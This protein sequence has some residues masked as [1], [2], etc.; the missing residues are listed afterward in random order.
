MISLSIQFL[1]PGFFAGLIFLSIPIL[2]HLFNFRR[3]KKVA[4][5]NVR[6]LRE[7]KE[8]TTKLNKLK[9]LLILICRLLAIAFIV[10]AF[11]KPVLPLE[12]QKKLTNQKNI[13][14]FV[15]NSF[16]M[17]GV[18][19]DG[20]LLEIAKKKAIE[21]ANAYPSS[22][23]FQLLTSDFLA[24][25]Q[26]LLTKEE[27][28]DEV[29]HIQIS[30][31]SK[32][33]SQVV[34][35]Q[36][37]AFNTHATEE[38][39]LFLISDFQKSSADLNQVKT[40]SLSHLNFI[41]LPVQSTANAYIDSC[42]IESPVVQLNK[43]VELV[44]RVANSGEEDMDNVPVVLK[45]NGSQRAVASCAVPAGNSALVKLSFTIAEPGWQK[46]KVSI[47]DQPIVFDDDYYLSF[48][49]KQNLNVI[50]LDGNNPG[51]YL[52]AL[53][54]N[55][56][57]FKF[58]S[59]PV[60]QVDYSVMQNNQVVILNQL[61]EISGGLTAELKKIV[62]KG[63]TV[64]CFPDTSIDINSYSTALNNLVGEGFSDLI[65]TNDKVAK[66]DFKNGIFNDVF[67]QSTKN[68]T[69]LDL[70]SVT[71]Y[72]NLSSSTN[73]TRNSLM[74][75][76]SGATFL[77]EYTAGKGKVYLFTVP[78]NSSFC[79]LSQHALV[80]PLLYKMSILS[81]NLIQNSAV[82]GE[83]DE[84]FINQNLNTADD[85]MH[86]INEDLKIDVVPQL[87][88]VNGGI[89]ISTNGLINR[90]GYYSLMN[91]NNNVA[92]FSFNYNRKES[93]MQF[94]NEDAL[95]SELETAHL[96]NFSFFKDQGGNL[97]KKINQLSEGIALWKYCII[98]AL[99]AFLAEI[100]II[101]IWKTV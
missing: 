69:N 80:V 78:L 4:F 75:L 46:L 21:I 42:W 26:R 7:L 67:D 63:G 22:A 33:I 9:H 17:E 15:D 19:K 36:L 53:F 27:F 24:V 38:K 30:P 32:S 29:D 93:V 6:F 82:L 50:S 79:N 45:I 62:E 44:V 77:A 100:L 41:E 81:M 51:P 14:I 97:T 28:V 48:E 40:D 5:T 1:A 60:N 61:K 16:S 87:K 70:P 101:R 12:N 35:R 56:P 47:T 37:D 18:T 43:T 71:A 99:L 55:D 84:F 13:S 25:H 95:K 66:L 10:F 23:R 91:S 57:F 54:A 59:V 92:V 11:T 31:N 39:E 83:K 89:Q 90:A 58:N 20:S 96:T 73:S 86:L 8:E 52:K 64:I 94:L 49:V 65:R 76:E 88:T 2:I 72:Y 34:S 68:Q 74:Q 98:I 85:V 3:Y